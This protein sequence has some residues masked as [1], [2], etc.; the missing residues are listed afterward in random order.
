MSTRDSVL[1]VNDAHVVGDALVGVGERA[2]D[3]DPIVHP[4][5][6]IEADQRAA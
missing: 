3:L 6:Q 5:L 1:V 4:L 2:A